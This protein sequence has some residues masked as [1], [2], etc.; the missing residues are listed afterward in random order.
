MQTEQLS[1]GGN[2]FAAPICAQ[3]QRPM[4]LRSIVR[5]PVRSRTDT[6]V[7]SDCGLIEKLTWL[8][9]QRRFQREECGHRP[10]RHRQHP[11]AVRRAARKL[12]H[13]YP[14]QNGII[15]GFRRR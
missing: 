2:Q 5:E 12:R 8:G 13:R 6:F 9:A 1:V 10:A 4:T 7:C 15:A 11:A 3:C 14:G